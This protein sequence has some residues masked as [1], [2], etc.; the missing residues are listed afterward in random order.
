VPQLSLPRSWTGVRRLLRREEGFGLIE[1]VMAMSMFAVVSAPLAGVMLASIAEQ[2]TS[3][4][5]T[6]AAQAAQ[7]EIEQ[8]RSLPYDSIG[9]VNGNPSGTVQASVQSTQLGIQGL[10]ATVNT[11]IAYMDDAP[12]TS[13]RTRADYK[14]VVVTVVRN[15]DMKKLTQEATYIAPP[16]GGAVAGQNQGIVIAQVIDYALNLPVVNASVN[17]SGGPSPARTDLTDASGQA[18]FPS[19]LPTTTAP[20]DHYDVTTSTSGYTTLKDDLP[21]SAT[22]R[23]PLAG[24][25]TFQTVI[26]VYKGCTINVSVANAN[27]TAYTGT[28]TLT[29][30]SSR[31]S[32]SFAYSGS[33]LSVTSLAGEPVVPNL[34]YTARFLAS[35]GSYS[36]PVTAL[37]PNAYPTDL[38]KSFLTTLNGVPLT[39]VALTVKVVNSS[40]VVQPNSTVTVSGGPGSNIL[41][42]GTTDSTGNAVFSVPSNSSPGYTISAKNGTLA[43]SNAAVGITSATTKTVTIK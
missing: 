17:V 42:T 20:T 29:L 25:Q 9:V 26:R 34:S 32:Q 33:A 19:L 13:Y 31:G 21:P 11:T 40:G 43:G 7:T 6:L 12:A 37:V 39:M 36:A 2:K 35:N 8:I 28:G 22:A 27:G 30:S 16:G 38:T 18:V 41:L 14:R 3:H 5:R 23:T 10:S 4:E 15:S 1:S 24:G